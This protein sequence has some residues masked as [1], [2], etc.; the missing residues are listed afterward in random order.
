MSNPMGKQSILCI[1]VLFSLCAVAQNKTYYISPGGNDAN[2]GL[3]IGSAWLSLSHL[4]TINF[5]PGDKVLLEGGQIFSG[6]ILIDANDAGT[7]ANPVTISSYGNGKAIINATNCTGIYSSNTGGTHI[8]NLII[9]GDGSDHDGIDV[10][11]NQTTADIESIAIDSIEVYGFGGRGCFIGAYSTDKGINHL[12]VQNSSFHDNDIAGLETFG[13]WPSFSH[14]DFTISYCKF[15]NNYGKLSPTSKPTGSGVV[16]SGVDGGVIE[17]CE[18]YN[19][20]LNNR[21]TG[22]GPVGIWA[23]DSKNITIQ[24]CE[25]HHNKAG[26]NSDGGGFDLDGGSQY[27]TVQYCYSHDNEGYGFALVEYGSPNEFTGNVIRYNISQNDARKNSYGAIALYA[28]DNSHPVTNSEIYNNTVYVDANNMTGGRPSAVNILTRNFSIVTIRNNI[29]YVDN[30]VDMINSQSSLSSTEIYFAA[31]NYYSSASLYDFLWNGSHYTSLDQWKMAASGQEVNSG[32]T[33]GIVQNPLLM[34]A[35]SGNT[36]NPADGGN[37][38][39]LFGYTLNPFSPLVDKAITTPN[40][41]SHDFFGN[42]LPTSSN[43]DIGASEAIPVTVLPLTI[44]SFKQKANGNDLQLQWR[45][46]N[47]EFLDRYEIQ[48]STNGSIYRTIGSIPAKGLESYSFIDKGWEMA[49]ADYRLV[50]YYPNGKFGISQ[51]INISNHPLKSD[52]AFYKEGSGAGLEIYSEGKQSASIFIYCSDG[53]QMYQSTYKL[54][55]GYNTITIPEAL[56]WRKGI[57]FIQIATENISTLQ[58]LK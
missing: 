15:Y 53:V 37:F 14:T 25:S 56:K 45:V 5:K 26:L 44:I 22:G 6:S 17:Y 41:G 19:N 54:S 39:S 3:S 50:Y 7:A 47:E 57:Y 34:N 11:I 35:G 58:F 55:E 24:Y 49:N 30:G 43:Y 21:S 29:F 23:Y 40:M 46:A 27:C 36:I 20:G 10:F 42:T 38:H 52:R 13:N 18:A 12:S 1:L 28:I 51:S 16:L 2:D 8:S 33:L 9:K 48:K 4:S 31:N 32:V